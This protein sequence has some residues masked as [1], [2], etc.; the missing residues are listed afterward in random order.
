MVFKFLAAGIMVFALASMVS[1]QPPRRNPGAAQANS[2]ED[3]YNFIRTRYF[4]GITLDD[5]QFTRVKVIVDQALAQQRATSPK[6][7]PDQ[8]D[9]VRVAVMRERNASLRT[10]LPTNTER[11]RCAP[12]SR[13]VTAAVPDGARRGR[14]ADRVGSVAGD[15]RRL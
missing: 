13:C 11:A 1:A 12:C 9:S 5:R 10:V 15:F 7:K 4:D 6:M 8:A 2:V 14:N 3:I